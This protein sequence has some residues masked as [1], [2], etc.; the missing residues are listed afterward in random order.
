MSPLSLTACSPRPIPAAADRQSDAM[1]ARLRHFRRRGQR[2][3]P[4]G[5]ADGKHRRGAPVLHVASRRHR[6]GDGCSVS[7]A[8]SGGAGLAQLAAAYAIGAT[9]H[10]GGR[11]RHARSRHP[12]AAT[13]HRCFGIRRAG[14][15]GHGRVPVGL[16][17]GAHGQLDWPPP[18]HPAPAGQPLRACARGVVCGGP[19]HCAAGLLFPSGSAAWLASVIPGVVILAFGR[20]ALPVWPLVLASRVFNKPPSHVSNKEGTS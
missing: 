2:A 15:A 3:A 18:R 12:A 7:D 14:G 6:L 9:G 10:S 4:A 17:L 13:R 19:G 11:R 1:G 5:P 20:L 16:H 8:H